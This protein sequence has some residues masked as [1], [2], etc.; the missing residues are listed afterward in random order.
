MRGRSAETQQFSIKMSAISM[1]YTEG[2]GSQSRTRTYD[3][4]VN[5]RLLYQLSYLGSVWP[6]PIAEARA[7]RKGATRRRSQ[8]P[9]GDGQTARARPDRW[10]S[11]AR[12]WRERAWSRAGV[13]AMRDAGTHSPFR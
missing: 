3:R 13:S 8:I 10:P 5:S 9:P 12:D 1:C 6:D 4:A 11:V 2:S 7:G